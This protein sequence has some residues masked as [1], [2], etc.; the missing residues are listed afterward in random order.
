MSPSAAVYG[1]PFP[2]FF[3]RPRKEGSISPPGACPKSRSGFSQE[4]V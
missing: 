2:L 3:F 1:F 4:F